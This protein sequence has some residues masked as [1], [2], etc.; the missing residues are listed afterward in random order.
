MS[1]LCLNV[2]SHVAIV[3]DKR[4]VYWVLVGASPMEGGLLEVLG[5]D[6]RIMLKW[7]LKK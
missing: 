5:V 1:A 6:G 7:F 3:G 2:Q 4:N